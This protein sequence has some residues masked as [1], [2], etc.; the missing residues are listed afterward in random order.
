[1]DTWI[2]FIQLHLFIVARIVKERLDVLVYT[3]ITNE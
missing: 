1:M 3:Y 2:S